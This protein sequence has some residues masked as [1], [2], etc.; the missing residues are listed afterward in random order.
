M[1]VMMDRIQAFSLMQVL[2]MD[3]CLGMDGALGITTEQALTNLQIPG[4]DRTL[5]Y[6]ELCEQFERTPKPVIDQEAN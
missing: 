6:L 1:R 4:A 2:E 5:L 3:L